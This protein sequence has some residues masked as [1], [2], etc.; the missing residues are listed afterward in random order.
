VIAMI[1]GGAEPVMRTA[2]G[3]VVVLPLSRWTAPPGPA[4]ERVLARA[5]GPVLDIGCGPG[6]HTHALA[7]AGVVTL[8][9]DT[10][11]TAVATARRRGCPVLR[12]SVY[13]RLPHEGRWGSALLIDGNVGI[14]GAPVGL[15][16]RVRALLAAAGRALVEVEPPG[17]GTTSTWA[18]IERGEVVGPW[19]AWARV[20]IDGIDRVAAPAGLR[21]TWTHQEEDRWFVQLTS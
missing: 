15:L 5:A 6:R 4:E 16:R 18:R 19:F 7:R 11:P 21:R 14:G 2:D 20:G 10:S 9:I 17:A 13:D 1:A 8:G 3:E 12:R